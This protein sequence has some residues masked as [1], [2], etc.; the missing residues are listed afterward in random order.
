MSLKDISLKS[1][2]RSPAQSNSENLYY[3]CLRNSIKFYRSAGFFSLQGLCENFDGIIELLKRNGEIRIITSP[4]L[5][6]EEII[7]LEDAFNKEKVIVNSILRSIDETKDLVDE[8][9]L[10]ALA[11]LIANG[12]IELKIVFNERGIYHEKFGYFVDEE[13]NSICFLGSDNESVAGHCDN[14]ELTYVGKSWENITQYNEIRSLF[15]DA[16]NGLLI[17]AHTID[18]PE[19]IKEKL[20]HD[21]S[22]VS[23]ED[24][25][26][27]YERQKKL[28]E[29]KKSL[30]E[31]QRNAM[32]Y[33][34]KNGGIGFLEMATGTGKTFTSCKIIEKAIDLY[35][36]FTIIIVPQIDLQSQWQKELEDLGISTFLLGGNG[37]SGV[38]VEEMFHTLCANYYTGIKSVGIA[39]YTTY[40][41]KIV[42]IN[43]NMNSDLLIVVDEAHNI[44]SNQI[45]KMPNTKYRLGLSAT[46]IK[47][48]ITLSR[49]IVNYFSKKN[50]TFK[51]TIEDAIKN[52]FLSHYDYHP[53]YVELD[54]QE[55]ASFKK[56]SQKL[57]ALISK[58]EKTAEDK[59]KINAIANDRSI[60]VKKAN[61]KM[62][63]LIQLLDVH[64][65]DFKRAVIYCGAGKSN[66]TAVD[67]RLIDSVTKVLNRYQVSCQQFTSKTDDRGAVLEKFKKDYY[68]VLVA[69][70]CFDEGVDVPQLEKIYIMA[71]DRLIRQTVQ[72]RGRV[73]RICKNS[74]KGKGYIYDFVVIPPNRYDEDTA[75]RSLVKMEFSRVRE[76]IRLADNQQ[77]YIDYIK[78]LE[79]KFNLKWDEGKSEYERDEI[80]ETDEEE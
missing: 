42:G 59:E 66:E 8:Y 13:D 23:T 20:L 67:E 29:K 52:G 53:L 39:T 28:F 30:F 72:R 25:I 4:K 79:E 36:A 5:R 18:I 9:K 22:L 48:D 71:S 43:E 73:L 38:M 3:P 16:W 75:A 26:L 69:I 21:Y 68:D 56:L 77:N 31:H 62:E 46:P 49:N 40:F 58:S 27:K 6:E 15:S 2:Y 47:H 24:A 12:A 70:H 55:F 57:A 78:S 32:D 34:F 33:F 35:N 64:K 51:F 74:G 10:E 7:I 19:V 60:I 41:E 11:L 14:I 65:H 80:D 63:K 17:N 44:S 54:E 45:K 50:D 76:Y 37:A 61:S 1:F